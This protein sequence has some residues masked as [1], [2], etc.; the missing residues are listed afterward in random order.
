MSLV[1]PVTVSQASKTVADE[2]ARRNAETMAT[3]NGVDR[4][5]P[6]GVAADSSPRFPR[7]PTCPRETEKQLASHRG[8]SASSV[9][10]AL[11]A[12]QSLA[13][14]ALAWATYHRLS[15][16]AARRA[17]AAAARIPVQR[18]AGVGTDRRPH[19]RAAA[20]AVDA[21]R[22]RQESA[23]LFRRAVRRARIRRAHLVHGARE[24]RRH[25]R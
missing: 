14:L 10:P 3:I 16:R 18:P 2:F 7:S 21:A 8:S 1:G 17:A 9:F 4:D 24:P 20:D 22:R 19:D 13:A 6:E 11:L 23:R 25:A 5:A 15:A 12:L